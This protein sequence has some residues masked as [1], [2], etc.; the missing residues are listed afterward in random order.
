MTRHLRTTAACLFFL[1]CTIPSFCQDI[2]GSWAGTLKIQNIALDLV[3]NI[4]KTDTG[5]TASMDSPDQGARG[6]PVSKIAFEKGVLQLSIPAIMMEYKGTLNEGGDK[7]SGTFTQRGQSIPLDL[8]RDKTLTKTKLQTPKTPY[9]YYTEEITFENKQAGIKLAGT[10]S[11]PSQKGTYP[12]VV[13]ISGSGP[14][15]RDETILGHKPFLVLADFLT[16]NGFAVLR[17]DDRGTAASGGDFKAAT[18][19]DFADDALAAVQY[20]SKR[21]EINKKQIGLI[22][23][24]EGGA[25]APMLAA[26]SANIGFIVMLA[27]PAMPGSELLLQQQKAIA[28]AEGM[29]EAQA[30]EANR[31]NSAL[32]DIVVR[33]KSEEEADKELSAYLKVALKLQPTNDSAQRISQDATVRNY[34]SELNNPWI[35]F[36]LK[37]NPAKDIAKVQCP[38]LALYG[39]KDVQVPAK[40]NAEALKEAMQQSKNEKVSILELPGLNHLFQEASTGAPSEYATI[41]QTFSP[42]AMN[43]IL[44]WLRYQVNHK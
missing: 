37:Y 31:I 36:F 35:R 38:V 17:Y 39:E 19:R 13:L 7:F 2:S 5:Y 24:S 21:K 29:P 22:G 42:K 34:V 44:N 15:D 14:Q 9:P 26:Q 30:E 4:K 6:I 28:A 43:E 8:E 23:H 16:R 40:A 11:M 25:I 33:S 20:L 12:A 3:L 18:S 27:G 32:Y 1:L 10:L 41:E